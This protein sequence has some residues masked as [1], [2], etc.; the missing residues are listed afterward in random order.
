MA[1]MM[2]MRKNAALENLVCTE[3]D[4]RLDIQEVEEDWRCEREALWDGDERTAMMRL[5][6]AEITHRRMLFADE[7]DDA[8]EVAKEIRELDDLFEEAEVFKVCTS[9][10]SVSRTRQQRSAPLRI[11]NSNNINNEQHQ[12][13]DEEGLITIKNSNNA[14]EEEEQQIQQEEIEI[15]Y[16]KR[17][18]YQVPSF[19]PFYPPRRPPPPPPPKS[20]DQI[21]VEMKMRK[22]RYARE[23]VEKLEN[24]ER[25]GIL[26]HFMNDPLPEKKNQQRQQQQ[27]YE[28][29][30]IEERL[31]NMHRMDM[32]APTY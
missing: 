5:Q 2:A 17:P 30:S 6:I 27:Q 16:L 23:T 29:G 31:A 22:E 3:R 14:Q 20:G 21:E 15:S 10:D 28:V 7:V 26:A 12:E 1:M 18:K 32:R 19:Q 25:D 11:T 9:P 13:Q 8:G 4:C 24:I